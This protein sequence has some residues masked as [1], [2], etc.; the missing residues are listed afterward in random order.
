VDEKLLSENPGKTFPT[1]EQ[2]ECLY[3]Y[4]LP[5]HVYPNTVRNS[6]KIYN[7]ECPSIFIAF[8]LIRRQEFSPIRR[9]KLEGEKHLKDVE[10]SY[11]GPQCLFEYHYPKKDTYKLNTIPTVKQLMYSYS[12]E[13]DVLIVDQVWVAIYPKNSKS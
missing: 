6:K 12:E 1:G 11:F 3:N 2:S 4:F 9:W 10:M 8:P 13:K 5:G 7:V